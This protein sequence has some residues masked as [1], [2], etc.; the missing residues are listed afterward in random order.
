MWY[1]ISPAAVARFTMERPNRLKTRLKEHWDTC[2]RGMMER[3]AVA[4]QV[5]ESHHPINWEE[6]SVL[7]RA[8][9]QGELLLKKA[10]HIQMTPA[11]GA[12]GWR[13]WVAGPH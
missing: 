11:T 4:E 5:W 12:E 1:I 9:G 13:S 7:G 6:T 3:L 10:L 8:G 2:E